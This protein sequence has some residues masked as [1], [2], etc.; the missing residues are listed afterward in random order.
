[1]KKEA[2]P[3]F[4]EFMEQCMSDLR[5][6]FRDQAEAV[7]REVVAEITGKSVWQQ[8]LRETPISLSA[9][10]IEA[11]KD[12]CRRRLHREP[13]QYITGKAFFMNDAFIVGRGVLIPR[14]DTERL[15]ETALDFITEQSVKQGS[16]GGAQ[17]FL[18]FCTGSGCV[19]ISLIKAARCREIDLRGTVTD[20]SD[21]AL[22]YARTN[23]HTLGV[24][25]Q[26][27][28]VHHDLLS[29]DFRALTLE[30]ARYD[31]IV[32]NPPY[33]RSDV[34]PKLEPEIRG[35]EPLLALD[36]GPDGLRFY[37]AL[38]ACAPDLLRPGGRLMVEIG[39][40]QEEEVRRILLEDGRFHRISVVHDY[41]GH[42]RVVVAERFTEDAQP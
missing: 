19:A 9:K 28:M 37:R 20:I 1:M 13:V 10:E 34:L 40:D 14:G 21:V 7:F 3:Q 4:H 15:V 39:Y 5:P 11:V 16:A 24:S 32:C 35:Y 17:R 22:Y 41:S 2:A 26:L 36:G 6:I 27:Q 29:G 25:Q 38:A 33:I 23:A 31:I 18:E 12:A 8:K 30:N 42:P